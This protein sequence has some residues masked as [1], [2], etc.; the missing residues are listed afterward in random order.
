MLGQCRGKGC[1]HPTMIQYK[2]PLST[3]TDDHVKPSQ[4]LT[5]QMLVKC[6]VKCRKRLRGDLDCWFWYD[7]FTMFKARG[8]RYRKNV[9]WTVC[10]RDFWLWNR[11]YRMLNKSR[12]LRWRIP[13]HIANEFSNFLSQVL[14]VNGVGDHFTTQYKKNSQSFITHWL[15]QHNLQRIS[16]NIIIRRKPYCYLPWKLRRFNKW[17]VFAPQTYTIG[18][19]L[20]VSCRNTLIFVI[21]WAEF[22]P[23]IQW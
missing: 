22:H 19:L 18:C 1:L 2:N 4:Q 6:W 16:R 5:Q 7:K 11:I 10:P 9:G 15:I 3:I 20:L 14:E 12:K 21:I 17:F 8:R 13:N 23:R